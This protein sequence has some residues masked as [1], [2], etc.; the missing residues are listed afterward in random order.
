MRKLI[1]VFPTVAVLLIAATPARASSRLTVAQDKALEQ[2]LQVTLTP[3]NPFTVDFSATNQ[4]I[5]SIFPGDRSRYVYRTEIPLDVG[6]STILNLLQIQP[7]IFPG[8]T[9]SSKP[10]L[11]VVTLESM[12]DGDRRKR[13]YTLTVSF[14]Q[15]PQRTLA[16]V[17]YVAAPLPSAAA[18]PKVFRTARGFNANL[19]AFEKGLDVAIARG[20]TTADDPAVY[21]VREFL[22]LLHNNA[23]LSVETAA[24]RVGLGLDFLNALAELGLKAETQ[25]RLDAT[26]PLVSEN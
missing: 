17:P 25:E 15:S 13:L 22:V 19:F 5:Q 16:I 21:K 20:L 8:T 2:P 24:E 18:A 4:C 14:G 12:P 1:A 23:A 10:S 26:G 7:V 6:C 3:G 9:R 11:Q